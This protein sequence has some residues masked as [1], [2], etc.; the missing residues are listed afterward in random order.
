MERKGEPAKKKCVAGEALLE[1][2]DRSLEL[3]EPVINATR[4][5]IKVFKH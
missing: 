5:R 1:P 4:P 3:R 2:M